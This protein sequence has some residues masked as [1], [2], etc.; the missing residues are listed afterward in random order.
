MKKILGLIIVLILTLTLSSCGSKKEEELKV[1]KIGA[2]APLSGPAA[3]WGLP[4]KKT[5]E[6]A[7]DELNEAGGIK[8]GKETYKVQLVIM[9][10]K[11]SPIDAKAAAEKLVLN[12]G[13]KFILGPVVS[14]TT[15]AVQTITEPNKVIIFHTSTAKDSTGKQKPY[16]FMLMNTTNQ[17]MAV[18]CKWLRDTYP[19]SKRYAIINP[20]NDGGRSETEGQKI[21]LNKYG[22]ELVSSEFYPQGTKDFYPI[23]TRMIAKKPDMISLGVTTPGDQGLV[24]KQLGELGYN[25]IKMINTSAMASLLYKVAGEASNGTIILDEDYASGGKFMTPEKQEFYDSFVSKYGTENWSPSTRIAYSFTQILFAAIQGAGT[26]DTDKVVEY[27]TSNEIN[28]LLGKVHT[29]SPGKRQGYAPVPITI[30]ENGKNKTIDMVPI[31]EPVP[32]MDN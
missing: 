2:L 6:L 10:T 3:P 1:L 27:I 13:I 9:D 26:L 19:D 15:L 17:R 11:A 22:L 14:A 32:G 28:T 31:P 25:K 16:S 20:D 4:M 7:F 23:L 8:V 30:L 5:F 12:D 29:G 24:L 21:L 18:L